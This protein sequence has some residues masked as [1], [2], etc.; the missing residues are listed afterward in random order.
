MKGA[1]QA[2]WEDRLQGDNF[3]IWVPGTDLG[4]PNLIKMFRTINYLYKVSQALKW[5]NKPIMSSGKT[6]EQ[7]NSGLGK[8]KNKM[9]YHQVVRFTVLWS[10]QA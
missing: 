8:E 7:R 9:N 6:Q 3:W 4:L 10:V 1:S 5:Q 2:A